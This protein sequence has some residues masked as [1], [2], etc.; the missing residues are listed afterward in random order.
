MIA[1]SLGIA[2]DKSQSLLENRKNITEILAIQFALAAEKNDFTQIEKTLNILVSRNSDILS[3][4]IRKSDG[5]F[6]AIAGAHDEHWQVNENGTPSLTHIQVPILQDDQVWGVVEISFAPLLGDN[7]LDEIKNSFWGFVLFVTVFGFL[8]YLLML[9]RVLRELDPS[10]VVPQRIKSAFDTLTEGILIL[11]GQGR[12]LLANNAFSQKVKLPPDS[13]IGQE[14]SKLNWEKCSVE[15]LKEDWLYPWFESLKRR[16]IQTRIR[17]VFNST[18]QNKSIFMINSSPIMGNNNQC[19]GALVTFDDVTEIEENNLK[20]DLMLKDLESSRNEISRQNNELK[21]LADVD[22]LTGFY[23][24]RALTLYFDEAFNLSREQDSNLICIMLDIDHFKSVNDNYGHQVGD[25]IIKLV[26]TI[27]RE[28]L[29]DTDIVGRYGGEEFCLVLPNIDTEIALKIAERI[30][31]NVMN[32]TAYHAFGIERVTISLG[33]SLIADGAKNTNE[34]IDLADKA[35]YFSKR[36]GRNRVTLWK[37]I[38]QQEGSAST[39]DNMEENNTSIAVVHDRA[40][41]DIDQLIGKIKELEQLN[42]KQQKLIERHINYDSGTGLLNRFGLQE[43]LKTA[44]SY[45][46]RSDCYVA[47]LSLSLNSYKRVYNTLGYEAAEKFIINASR[48][49]S[50]ILRTTDAVSSETET[51]GIDSMLSRKNESGFYILLSELQKNEP[52]TQIINRIYLALNQ[53]LIIDGFNINTDSAIGV[54]IYPVD[55]LNPINLLNYAD[56]ALNNAESSGIGT[57]QFYSK[58]MNHQYFSE[59]QLESDLIHAIELNQFEVFYQP[60]VDIKHNVISKFEALLRWHHPEKGILTAASFIDIAER[61]G[62]ILH[63]G[64]WVLREAIKQLAIWRKEVSDEIQIS[65]NISATQMQF[66]DLAKKILSYLRKYEVPSKNLVLEITESM[67]MQSIEGSA[68]LL[69]ELHDMGVQ[70]ALD[71]FGMGYAS[72][73]YLQKFPIDIVKID[74]SFISDINENSSNSAIVLAII[75]MSKKMGMIVVAEG[76]ETEKQFKHLYNL[77]CDEAQGYL[78]GHPMP[79]EHAY[80]ALKQL[81]LVTEKKLFIVNQ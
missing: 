31:T 14:V 23:N 71:D 53:A 8:G 19:K 51:A 41:I 79:K 80:T 50:N 13:L 30:R 47:I 26:T 17:L 78:L 57:C 49:I 21:K 7:L 42:E 65:V 75:E 55:D 22:P 10:G 33:I 12:I 66:E 60:I 3:G 68:Q 56:L 32:T 44:I 9:K 37:D 74:R 43:R 29:R 45:A 48:R 35:L 2:P 62:L 61:S 11:D 38:A 28:S 54:S 52:I 81:S 24:R 76:V 34:M 58:E 64:D 70:I 36:N 18:Q 20:L 59:I 1:Q 69:N 39:V 77:K 40:N 67:I 6:L 4:A 25:E 5:V 46:A 15:Q 27:S 63:I 72:F 73:Q 16:K